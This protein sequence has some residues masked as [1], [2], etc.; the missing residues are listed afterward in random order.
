MENHTFKI[1]GAYYKSHCFPSLNDYINEL[2]RHPKAG[3]RMKQ[4][5]EMIACNAIRLGLKRFSTQRRIVLHYHFK[6]PAKGNKRDR[7]NVFSFADKVIEDA[8]QRCNVI[9]DDGPEIVD[10][11]TH[12]FEF[13]KG[14]PEIEVWIQEL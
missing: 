13:T 12:T 4:E 1:R 14:K 5:Y 3:N 10:N 11:T 6:E 9:P 2:G 7:M 8:L